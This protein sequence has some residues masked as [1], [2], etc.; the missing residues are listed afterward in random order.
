MQVLWEIQKNS[1][2]VLLR[3]QDIAYEN[4]G[5][6]EEHLPHQVNFEN[7]I[8]DCA[9][10]GI[11]VKSKINCKLQLRTISAPITDHF[12]RTPR[13]PDCCELARYAL[14]IMLLTTALGAFRSQKRNALLATT[15]KRLCSSGISAAFTALSQT[16]MAGRFAQLLLSPFPSYQ[17]LIHKLPFPTISNVPLSVCWVRHRISPYIH[18]TNWISGRLIRHC[19]SPYRSPRTIDSLSSQE[20]REQFPIFV[21]VFIDYAYYVSPRKLLR[22]ANRKYPAVGFKHG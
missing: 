12:T 13:S 20:T 21:C 1:V 5:D 22:F 7:V 6:K 17:F 8:C 16:P 3:S 10:N 15:H 4:Y 19:F 14:S 11:C 18:R 9:H 2:E